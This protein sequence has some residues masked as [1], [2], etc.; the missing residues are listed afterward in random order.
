VVPLNS[1][2]IT[3]SGLVG[4]GSD[5]SSVSICG[6]SAT[7]LSQSV[8]QV[9]VRAPA[10]Q[11]PRVCSLLVTATGGYT[12]SGTVTYNFS[13]PVVL[14]NQ[15]GNCFLTLGNSHCVSDVHNHVLSVPDRAYRYS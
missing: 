9:V 8:T 1:S 10:V 2:T 12:A 4:T 3:I 7:L 14:N 15:R 11:T 13:T 6:I 5:V